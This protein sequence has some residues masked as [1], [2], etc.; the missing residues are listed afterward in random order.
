MLFALLICHLSQGRCGGC[1]NKGKDVA[2][3]LSSIAAG[4]KCLASTHGCARACYADAKYLELFW[5]DGC[6]MF[7]CIVYFGML[8]KDIFVCIGFMLYLLDSSYI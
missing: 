4:S 1:S 5:V 6:Q 3:A 7:R 8:I 2:S